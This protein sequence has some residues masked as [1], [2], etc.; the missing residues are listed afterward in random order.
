MVSCD[1]ET[2]EGRFYILDNVLQVREAFSGLQVPDIYIIV[3]REGEMPLPISLHVFKELWS[4]T[5]DYIPLIFDSSSETTFFPNEPPLFFWWSN[6]ELSSLCIT[7]K[8]KDLVALEC[9][10]LNQPAT[11]GVVPFDMG[12]DPVS[13]LEV[14]MGSS[15]LRSASGLVT[16]CEIHSIWA[17]CFGI[18]DE[19]LKYVELVR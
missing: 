19:S 16:D 4:N 6:Q 15:S 5:F 11:D 10:I 9:E 2:I 17:V 3:F 18:S 8:Q 1:N 12:T 13:C 7:N 14:R